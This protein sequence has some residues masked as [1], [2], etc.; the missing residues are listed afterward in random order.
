MTSFRAKTKTE[1]NFM[2]NFKIQGQIYDS[3][4]NSVLPRDDE[5]PKYLQIQYI[6]WKTINV[7]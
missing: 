3:A 1:S 5:S 7:R 2:P 6:L 4:V